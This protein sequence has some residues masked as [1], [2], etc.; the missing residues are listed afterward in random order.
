VAA[1]FLGLLAMALATGAARGFGL[2]AGL[3]AG[4]LG[5]VAPGL[6][7]LA[8]RGRL[9]EALAL[10]PL[11]PAALFLSLVAG[12]ALWIFSLG[13]MSLQVLWWAPPEEFLDTF[14]HLHEALRPR[15]PLD[16]IVSIAAIAILPAACEEVVFRGM[17]LPAF[18][19]AAGPA[20]GVGVTAL[21][22]GLIHVQYVPAHPLVLDRVPF[23]IAVGIGL[24][25]L[26]LRAASLWPPVLA[27][28]ALNTLTFAVVLFTPAAGDPVEE[29]RLDVGL[30]LLAAGA[31]AFT[32]FAW[33]L[34]PPAD[35]SGLGG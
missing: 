10:R 31:L 11:S 14:R 8:V 24:G 26:R 28:A 27:H 5:L 15:G 29:G 34:R 3:M 13:L 33:G 35:R 18:V 22:F 2:R 7:A 19:K 20:A 25:I 16:A 12:G 9:A 17:L 30:G 32:L 23:A 21:L 6:L 1:L 4:E